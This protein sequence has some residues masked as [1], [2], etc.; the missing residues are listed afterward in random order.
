VD[1]VAVVWRRVVKAERGGDRVSV[2]VTILAATPLAVDHLAPPGDAAVDDV[3]DG[4]AHPRVLVVGD[5]NLEGGARRHELDRREFINRS[6]PPLPPR[7]WGRSLGRW[8]QVL[9][10]R[11][12]HGSGPEDRSQ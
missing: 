5:L 3:V 8:R 6:R 7:C 1:V 4:R 10:G 11:Q 2:W 12:D 9:V